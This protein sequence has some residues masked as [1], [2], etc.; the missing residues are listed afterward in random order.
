MQVDGGYR[1][2]GIVVARIGALAAA[3][4]VVSSREAADVAGLRFSNARTVEL[5]GLLDPIELVTIDWA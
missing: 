2:K 4:E 1:G 5:K 3:D